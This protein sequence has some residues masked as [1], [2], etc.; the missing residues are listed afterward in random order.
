MARG[1]RTEKAAEWRERFERFQRAGTSIAQFCRREGISAVSFYLWRRKLGQKPAGAGRIP[2]ADAPA[3]PRQGTFVPVRVLGDS[4][5]GGP[6]TLI[7][8]WPG[9]TRLTIPLVDPQALQVT[10]AALAQADA[11]RVGGRSC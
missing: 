11:E 1:M 5:R 6:P 7:A 4:S 10:I 3:Q 9:G 2:R 8:E